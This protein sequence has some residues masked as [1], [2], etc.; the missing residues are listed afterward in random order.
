MKENNVENIK[1]TELENIIVNNIVY[2][3]LNLMNYEFYSDVEE[4]VIDYQYFKDR[5]QEIYDLRMKDVEVVLNIHFNS[6]GGCLNVFEAMLK[7][8]RQLHDLGVLLN[9]N[10]V[11]DCASA[12]AYLIYALAKEKLC[13]FSFPEYHEPLLIFHIPRFKAQT[14]ELVD[15]KTFTSLAMKNNKKISTKFLDLIQSLSTLSKTQISEFNRGRDIY[16]PSEVFM[17]KCE[18]LGILYE[19]ILTIDKDKEEE[20]NIETK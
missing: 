7:D 15:E 4:F 1:T 6:N 10:I 14:N 17:K 19:N 5:I 8:F 13:T 18:E 12:G 9:I 2:K 11:D 20:Q 3:N 16:I